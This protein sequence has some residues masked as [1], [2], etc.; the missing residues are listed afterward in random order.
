MAQEKK[1]G[2]VS[3][4][5][6]PFRSVL[7]TEPLEVV[8]GVPTF[9]SRHD[10][11][12]QRQVADTF[13]Y[14]W[15]RTPRWGVTG[16]DI[17]TPWMMGLLGFSD[18]ASYAKYLSRF[19]IIL[20]AGCG[21]GR[22]TMRMA[23]LNPNALVIGLD[24]SDGIYAAAENAKGIPNI[25]FVRGDLCAPP[26]RKGSIDYAFS[27]G[28]LHHTPDTENAFR[29]VAS[30]VKPGGEFSFYVYRKKAPLREFADDHVRGAIAAMTPERAWQEMESITVLGRELSKLKATISIPAVPTLGI[31]GGTHDIQRLIYYTVFKCYWNDVLNFD[32][33]VHV[34]YDWYAP[35]YSWRHTEE[36]V[37]KW[38]AKEGMTVPFLN[39][40]P[41]G[42]AF[43]AARGA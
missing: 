33:N 43:R 12:G 24:I 6:E 30:L 14:K 31:D 19:S 22:E 35:K 41:A 10:D 42:F 28:V 34:N 37:R 36:E 21:N 9:I 26:I 1:I 4:F 3:S 16:V 7:S 25:R 23:R 11:E 17:M 29:S 8:R 13:G 5:E 20:D 40:I 38:V 27:F 32:D 2:A 18:E 39:A 15:T